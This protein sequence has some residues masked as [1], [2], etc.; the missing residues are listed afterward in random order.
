LEID[1]GRNPSFRWG[2]REIDIDILFYDDLVYTCQSLTI[3]HP[4]LHER[5]FVLVPL[6]DLAPEFIHPVLKEPVSE[7]LKKVDRGGIELYES[8]L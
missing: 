3:P 1:L 4:S 5:A 7:L 2:P 8:D 6:A